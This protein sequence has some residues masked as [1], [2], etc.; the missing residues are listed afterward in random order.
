MKLYE[1]C[2]IG[3]CMGISSIKECVENIHIHAINLFK[4]D[5]I[6]EELQELDKEVKNGEYKEE[7]S[8]ALVLGV[9][10]MIE[11]DNEINE[12]AMSA[13]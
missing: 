7:D 3:Y 2:D 10:R 12:W 4:Y 5:D 13:Q 11:I 6:I 9:K 8:V 1:A